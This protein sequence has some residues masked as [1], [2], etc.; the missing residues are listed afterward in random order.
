MNP[1]DDRS[2]DAF[3]SELRREFFPTPPSPSLAR[4]VAAALASPS[5]SPTPTPWMVTFLR[6]HA[7][8]SWAS[9]ATAAALAAAL[10]LAN[11]WGIRPGSATA[12]KEQR[13][14]GRDA[15]SETAVAVSPSPGAESFPRSAPRGATLMPARGSEPAAGSAASSDFYRPVVVRDRRDFV[16]TLRWRERHTGAVLEVSYPRSEFRLVAAE[17]M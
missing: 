13:E 17:P 4:G 1:H 9:F 14:A 10:L 7:W 6:N 3:A 11:G 2:L 16:D 12:R 15:S 8:L 5:L